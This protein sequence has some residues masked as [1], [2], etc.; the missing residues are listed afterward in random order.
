MILG[1]SK[2]LISLIK[3]EDLAWEAIDRSFKTI[4][5]IISHQKR[6]LL[7]IM[8]LNRV[9]ISMI[10]FS[11]DII[12]LISKE[13]LKES[14]HRLSKRIRRSKEWHANS[15]TWWTA[16]LLS[17]QLVMHIKRICLIRAVIWST[18][19]WRKVRLT[20]SV[21]WISRTSLPTPALG[22][23]HVIREVSKAFSWSPTCKC[24]QS[25][26]NI[27]N[28]S[29]TRPTTSC[30][31]RVWQMRPKVTTFKVIPTMP[32]MQILW[33]TLY[34]HSRWSKLTNNHLAALTLK[35]ISQC[36]LITASSYP[37]IVILNHR[38]NYLKLLGFSEPIKQ[39]LSMQL[40]II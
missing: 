3:A 39:R 12:L 34:K 16:Q 11:I 33:W 18:W 24:V 23:R 32:H 9:L 21:T 35:W 31:T 15:S 30:L 20:L 1:N 19:T 37:D 36:S 27:C 6:P 25:R 2:S 29:R 17:S 26:Q 14:R 13:I 7:S 28:T 22:A 38:L 5:L 10:P 8:E 40:L 4:N